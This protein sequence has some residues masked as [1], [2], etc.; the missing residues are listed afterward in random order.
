MYMWRFRNALNNARRDNIR[1]VHACLNGAILLY[2]AL[3]KQDHA[4]FRGITR[5]RCGRRQKGAFRL[6]FRGDIRA[7]IIPL[8]TRTALYAPGTDINKGCTF[9][10]SPLHI[11]FVLV[12][13]LEHLFLNPDPDRTSQANGAVEA[14]QHTDGKRNGER[15]YRGN[16][17]ESA[18][19]RNGDHRADRGSSRDD[20]ARHRLVD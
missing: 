3:P 17:H 8:L 12:A 1:H 7:G 2:S 16:A 19:D 15:Q 10:R 18:H 11:L 14:N 5:L 20:G 9:L 6:Y 4:G 13:L